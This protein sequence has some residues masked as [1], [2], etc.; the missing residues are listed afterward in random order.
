MIAS[1]TRMFLLIACSGALAAAERP[2]AGLGQL[3]EGIAGIQCQAGLWCDPEPGQCRTVDRAGMCIEV[4]PFC[5]REYRPVCGC[6]GKT[7][8]NECERRSARA[9]MD[10]DGACAAP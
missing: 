1:A 3:C 5:T 2:R 6:D 8:G 9:A 4:R 10:H 7:Y